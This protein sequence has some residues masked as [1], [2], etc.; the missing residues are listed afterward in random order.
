[1]GRTEL[2]RAQHPRR[3]IAA[4]VHIRFLRARGEAAQAAAAAWADTEVPACIPAGTEAGR[5]WDWAADKAR[6]RAAGRTARTGR[7]SAI[8]RSY[9][10][11]WLC[12]CSLDSYHH[13][14]KRMV[15]F[16]LQL[17]Y[18]A[19]PEIVRG[20]ALLLFRPNS[21]IMEKNKAVGGVVAMVRKFICALLAVLLALPPCV[22]HCRRGYPGGCGAACRCHADADRAGR[23][24]EADASEEASAPEEE[25]SEDADEPGLAELFDEF[26]AARNLTEDNFAISYYDT[27]T[28]ES[29]D[30]NETHDDRGQYLQASAESLLLRAR[31]R[32]RDRPDAL[33]TQGGAT[34][35]WCHYLSIVESNNEISTRFSTAS[36]I[37]TTTK[38]PC[39]RILR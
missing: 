31:K 14:S 39:A 7:Y 15:F 13:S 11:R 37:F 30:W 23:R 18:A 26:R 33:I 21:T 28:G 1:M 32:G 9:S 24:T 17:R 2:Q 5:D 12:S 36:A 35:D 29:Y 10:R 25:P 16:R 34:L 4:A 20:A 27:V 6:V 8:G 19:L 22:F 3:A 38:T